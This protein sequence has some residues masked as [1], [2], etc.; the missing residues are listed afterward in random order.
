MQNVSANE[1]ARR[2]NGR[3]QKAYCIYYK[4]QIPLSQIKFVKLWCFL[5]ESGAVFGENSFTA[6][7][8]GN[9]LTFSWQSDT[10]KAKHTCRLRPECGC[11]GGNWGETGWNGLRRFCGVRGC[12]STG[13]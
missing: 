3:R 10:I 1:F 9:A 4:L 13:S 11:D 7:A 8:A 6:Q 5:Q 2:H 12:L